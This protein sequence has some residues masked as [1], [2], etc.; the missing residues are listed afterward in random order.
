MVANN[1]IPADLAEA[2][3]FHG[4]LCPGL[5]IGYLAAKAGMERLKAIRSED[6][7]LIAIVEN[8]SC[9]VDAVQVLTGCTTGKGNLFMRDYGKMVFTF[10]M[11]PSGKAVRVSLIRR[12]K[13]GESKQDREQRIEYMLS[14]RP[15]ELFWVHEEKIDWPA[16]ATIHEN[17]VCEQCGEMMMDTR[18]R[19][20]GGAVLCIPCAEEAAK[21]RK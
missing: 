15:E 9:A 2:I 21:A 14:A 3:K 1:S 20:V 10:A 6:E 8:D 7:E 12:E 17:A 11:R 16:T 4:H 13:P 18:S 5:V 19:C